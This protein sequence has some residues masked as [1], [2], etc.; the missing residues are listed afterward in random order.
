MLPDRDL[1]PTRKE[2]VDQNQ[3]KERNQC[4]TRAKKPHMDLKLSNIVLDKDGIAVLNDISG[5]GGITHG[6]LA[7]EIRDEISP[8]D[9]PFQTRRPNDIW[10]Y[11]KVLKEI[12]SRRRLLCEETKNG[13]GSFNS[14]CSY[15]SGLYPRQFLG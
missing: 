10:A 2:M 7:P 12:A 4:R 1:P 11:G 13:C 6:W 15:P 14:R 8:F 5:V 9:L 3:F